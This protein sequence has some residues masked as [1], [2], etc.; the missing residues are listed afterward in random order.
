MFCKV[1]LLAPKDGL[2]LSCS[3][4]WFTCPGGLGEDVAHGCNVVLHLFREAGAWVVPREA[5]RSEILKR[6]L[7]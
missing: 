7:L 5:S 6:A 3:E 2:F 1:V 4:E